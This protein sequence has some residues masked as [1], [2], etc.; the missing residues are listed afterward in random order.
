M[1]QMSQQLRQSQE[2]HKEDMVSNNRFNEANDRSLHRM[3][4]RHLHTEKTL[5][6]MTSQM[7]HY[8]RATPKKDIGR[9][10]R[11][12]SSTLEGIM[13]IFREDASLE[14]VRQMQQVLLQE[15]EEL[16]VIE[17]K[18]NT[19]RDE[20]RQMLA[21]IGA[22]D[23]NDLHIV[24]KKF[25]VEKEELVAKLQSDIDELKMELGKQNEFNKQMDLVED[26]RADTNE[27]RNRLSETEQTIVLLTTENE[28][29]KYALR[30]SHHR[31]N[32]MGKQ[33][34]LRSRPSTPTFQ[35]YG[36]EEN[37]GR[38]NTVTFD[39]SVHRLNKNITKDATDFR[40]DTTKTAARENNETPSLP[41]IPLSTSPAHKHSA[42]LA[43]RTPKSQNGPILRF[44]RKPNEL[45]SSY[46]RNGTTRFHGKKDEMNTQ[47]MLNPLQ[48]NTFQKHSLSSSMVGLSD[49]YSKQHTLDISRRSYQGM[50]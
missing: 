18:H 36:K 50:R 41:L 42:R 37:G 4:E 43:M 47:S 13:D 5:M 12:R 1:G 11:R 20:R 22:S 10:Q 33:P 30:S 15:M 32:S 16:R 45:S 26:L 29:L 7:E 34:S 19:F 6:D 25:V 8:V 35:N 28:K 23:D 2:G 44:N 48:I 46:G 39:T 27:L 31:R 49:A 24:F 17:K 14:K 38:T 9:K 3:T 21:H 40:I